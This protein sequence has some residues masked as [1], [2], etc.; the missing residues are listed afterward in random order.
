MSIKKP[1]SKKQHYEQSLEKLRMMFDMQYST[2]DFSNL[3][4]YNLNSDQC[5][6]LLSSENF[7]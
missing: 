5:L 7:V 4:I 3:K 1:E 6:A 2:Q